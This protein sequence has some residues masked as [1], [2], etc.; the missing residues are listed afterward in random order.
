MNFDM[1]KLDIY[2]VELK[3]SANHQNCNHWIV[4]LLTSLLTSC[5]YLWCHIILFRIQHSKLPLDSVWSWRSLVFYILI[6]IV[7]FR[8]LLQFASRYSNWIVLASFS[9]VRR[10]SSVQLM[11]IVWCFSFDAWFHDVWPYIWILNFCPLMCLLKFCSE[12]VIRV[13]SFLMADQ[14]FLSIVWCFSFDAW[15]HDVWPYIWLLN[16]S[17]HWCICWSSVLNRS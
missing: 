6:L 4:K 17:V 13:D 11:S 14:K 7:Y 8:S 5:S 9:T 16:V 10:I 12:L 1:I 15:L 3:I 2:K